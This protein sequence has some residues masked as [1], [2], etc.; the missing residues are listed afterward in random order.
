V[1]TVLVVEDEPDLRLLAATLLQ[2]EGFQVLEAGSGERALVLLR[3]HDVRVVLL[4]I[5]LPGMSGWEV[6]ARI[7]E[8]APGSRPGV[9]MSSAHVGPIEARRAEELGATAYLTKPYDDEE[10]LRVVS[11]AANAPV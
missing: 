5:K 10:L 3:E 6:L 9:V 11:A 4:D 8:D 7:R 1:T 2:L